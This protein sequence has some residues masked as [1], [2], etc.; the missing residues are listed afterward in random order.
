[1]FVPPSS[2]R[3]GSEPR[4]LQFDEPESSGW[5]TKWL[6]RLCGSSTRLEGRMPAER[7]SDGST[8][9]RPKR[10]LVMVSRIGTTRHF[11]QQ[12]EFREILMDGVPRISD[13]S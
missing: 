2:E 6:R 7:S 5:R 4:S 1:M 13:H 12:E 10:V 11:E 3:D 9:W 8:D